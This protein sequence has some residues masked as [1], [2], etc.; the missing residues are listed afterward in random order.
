MTDDEKISAVEGILDGI[1]CRCVET[2]AS[3][4]LKQCEYWAVYY[5][6]DKRTHSHQTRQ[7]GKIPL[8]KF[9][10]THWISSIDTIE[11]LDGKI[12]KRK[13]I[14]REEESKPCIPP[15]RR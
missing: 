3:K 1:L 9:C 11:T 5:V 4:I 13:K 12:I 7:L 8:C 15:A 10:A 14:K 6:T 2:G